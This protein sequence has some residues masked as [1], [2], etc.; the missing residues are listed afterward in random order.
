MTISRE[1]LDQWAKEQELDLIGVASPAW[2]RDVEAQWNP[3]S[4][5]PEAKAIIVFAREI[6]RSYFRGIEEGKLW[7]RVNR[8]LA[9]A[10]AYSL[11]RRFED[12]ASLAV[13]CSPLAAQR[14]PDGLPAQ[15]GKVAPN[16]T[17]DIYM[18][19]QLAGL[20]EIAYNG[21]F[22]TPQFG[23]RQAL[24]ML[25]TDADIAADTP[26]QTGTLCDRDN[27]QA[28][29][30][31]CPNQALTRQTQ[32]RKVGTQEVKVGIYQ[33]KICRFCSNGCYADTS[34]DKAPP[35]RLAAACSRACLSH[36]E[37]E[38]IIKTVFRAPFRRRPPWGFANFEV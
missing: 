7:M 22:I 32:I 28:C 36:L 2:Y 30:K 20:G 37:D 12:H 1:Q 19:A 10:D 23:I 5:M 27:C 8:L 31:A 18:A 25:F 29:I 6:P 33:E 14:W 4:I 9:P 13:P 34:S 3:L 26:F 15:A 24:G 16:V 35:N 38:G 21:G 17:P 11:C